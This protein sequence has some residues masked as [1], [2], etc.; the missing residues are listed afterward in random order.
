MEDKKFRVNPA[1]YE[2]VIVLPAQVGALYLKKTSAPLLKV[3]ICLYA[4][5]GVPAD[6]AAVAE[7]TG[8]SPEEAE[9]AL[10]YWTGKGLLLDENSVVSAARTDPPADGQADAPA[11]D[12]PEKRKKQTADLKP[13]KPTYAVICKRTEESEAVRELFR[14]AQLKLGRTIGLAD[15]GSLLLLHDYYGLPVEII[16]TL[17]EYA[18]THG[19]ANNLNYIYTVGVDWSRREIDTLELADAEFKRIEAA[20]GVWS[21]LRR[22]TGLKNARPTVPQQKYLTVWTEQWGFSLDMLTLAY[23]EMSRNTDGVSFPYMNKILEKW[24]QKNVTTPEE[25]AA[26]EKSFREEKDKKSAEKAKPSPYGTRQKPEQAAAPASYDIEKAAE[27]MKTAVP[28][29]KKREKR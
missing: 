18:R 14:E 10:L 9:D 24:K 8:L 12:T 28:K 6:A 22:Q 13:T 21:A 2:G 19:K 25:A 27:Q 29:L 1:A 11:A 5:P 7:K 20:D 23:E 4:E 15:Q 26:L 17:C 16:L 3:L